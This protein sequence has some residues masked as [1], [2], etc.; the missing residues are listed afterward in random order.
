MPKE[1]TPE[2]IALLI[3]ARK[4]LN[5]KG[6]PR[7]ID[8]S[9]ICEH[10]GISRKTGYQWAD[11]LEQNEKQTE[12]LQEELARLQTDHAKLKDEFED[13]SFENRGR[14]L[15]WEIHSVDELLEK[16]G[17]VTTKQRKRKKR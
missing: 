9:G 2:E 11:K 15:A 8:V 7:N 16:K 12:Q 1:L 14:K 3:Q 6:M 17:V 4:I 13:V 5:K 10:A